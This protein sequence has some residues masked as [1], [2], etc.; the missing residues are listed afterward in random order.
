[1]N[2]E[3]WRY[4]SGRIRAIA[5]HCQRCNKI[6]FKIITKEMARKSE[7]NLQCYTAP[8]GWA[9]HEYGLLCPECNA[10]YKEFMGAE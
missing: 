5:F 3:I 8:Q 7:D 6:E 10:K 9:K 4:A 1:M 2:D